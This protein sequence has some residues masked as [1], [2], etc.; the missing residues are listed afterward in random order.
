M[1]SI[2]IVKTFVLT[3]N[4]LAQFLKSH[5]LIKAFESITQDVT[6]TLPQAI[7]DSSRD[8]DSVLST[9]A[10]LQR[11]PLMPPT[12]EDAAGSILAGEVF[13]QRVPQL[14]ITPDDDAS[15][16]IANHIFG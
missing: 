14:V 13:R 15:R 6:E 16:I 3:R 9:A 2:P 11:V 5:E 12:F 10:F 1:A 7:A 8:P 4:K